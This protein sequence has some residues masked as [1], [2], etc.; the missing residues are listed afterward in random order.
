MLSL[1]QEFGSGLAG[2]FWL[3]E[4]VW[5]LMRSLSRCQLGLLS[6]EGLTGA[7]SS[8]FKVT[9]PLTGLASWCWLLVGGLGSFAQAAAPMVADL[10]QRKCSQSK[11]EAATPYDLTSEVAHCHFC[12]IL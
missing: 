8:A 11:A 6:L 3:G 7:G 4:V 10:P 9:R 5:S 2:C 12:N 1:C